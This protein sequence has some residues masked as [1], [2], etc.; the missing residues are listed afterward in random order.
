MNM[1][2]SWKSFNV[3]L[4]DF[5]AWLDANLPKADGLVCTSSSCIIVETSSLTPSEIAAVQAYFDSLT[6]EGEAAK[7]NRPAI[8]Q[9]KYSAMKEACI[10]KSWDEMTTLERK[11]IARVELSDAEKDEVFDYEA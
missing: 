8:L 10:S 11:I 1:V 2:L 4:P 5:K 9:A 3:Y 7:F 6:E